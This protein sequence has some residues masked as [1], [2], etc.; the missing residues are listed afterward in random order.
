[1]TSIIANNIAIEY[2]EKGQA[3]DPVI[4]LI[5]GLGTQLIDWP[6]EFIDGL[7]G[8]G[9]RVI[10]HDNRDAGLSA[11]FDDFGTP[12]LLDTQI[13]LAQ[14][15]PIKPPYTLDDMALDIIGL[16]DK[17]G[18]DK[19]HILGISMGG[20]IGQKLAA[21]HANRVNSLISIMSG[22]GNPNLPPPKPEAM[23]VLTGSPENPN[24]RE[25][26]IQFGMRVLRVLDSPGYPDTEENMRKIATARYERSYCPGGV[27]RQIMAVLADGSRVDMLKTI[28]VPTLVIHGTD[29]PLAPVEGGK[30]TAVNIPEA[31][32]ELVEGMGHNIPVPLV[33][34]LV[35]LITEHAR[36]Y[37]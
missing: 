36:K 32:L 33:P 31:R 8:K 17:L 23:A 19:A 11:K 29:D 35:D 10:Y 13:K 24:D 7:A 25:T 26:I 30:D 18:I 20:F 37:N 34:R 27:A 22:T 21:N 16:M 5:R 6:D 15:E 4:I 14:G 3:D 9:F 2:E 12:D 28:R 1:M